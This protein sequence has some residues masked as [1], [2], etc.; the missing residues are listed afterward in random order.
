MH[1]RRAALAAA[2]LEPTRGS[3]R[4]AGGCAVDGCVLDAAVGGMVRECACS[5]TRPSR[6]P[7][8][9]PDSSET[10]GTRD[11]GLTDAIVTHART[12]R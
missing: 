8:D 2:G 3:R 9:W 5:A 6:Y 4:R 10:A 1:E 12:S 11:L 7:A